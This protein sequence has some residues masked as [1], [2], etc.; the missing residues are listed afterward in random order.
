MFEYLN[1]WKWYAH[2][3]GRSIFYVVRTDRPPHRKAKMIQMHRVIMNT[4]IGLE[5]DH[6]DHNGL[7]NQRCNLRN[8]TRSQNQMNRNPRGVSKYL[9]VS[10][11]KQAKRFT[12][13]IKV[14]QKTIYGGYY[15]IEEDA[16]KIYDKLALKY[17]GEF[18]NLNFPKLKEQYMAEL[19]LSL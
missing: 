13:A 5:V 19:S 7:N 15:L 6:I 1:Q 3:G 17:C 12:A 8:C 9:G 14:A 10:Y 2:I 11:K 16:A 18:A 4:P